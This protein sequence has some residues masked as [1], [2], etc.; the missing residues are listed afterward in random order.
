[1][2]EDND[3]FVLQT[4]KKYLEH[5]KNSNLIDVHGLIKIA[6]TQPLLD[7]KSP[8]LMV[9]DQ[10]I[11]GPTKQLMEVLFQTFEKY[12]VRILVLLLLLDC[13]CYSA[14]DI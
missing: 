7:D 9:C 4:K 3:S 11:K 12:K 2:G 10:S 1:M 5:L 6:K 14:I 8:I 13:K